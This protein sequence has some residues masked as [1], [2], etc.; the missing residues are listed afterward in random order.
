MD[1]AFAEYLDTYGLTLDHAQQFLIHFGE[2]PGDIP[3]FFT[4]MG[5]APDTLQRWIAH[6]NEYTSRVDAQ[7]AR[8]VADPMNAAFGGTFV[9]RVGL[10]TPPGLTLPVPYG[11]LTEPGGIFQGKAC[12]RSHNSWAKTCT[13]WKCN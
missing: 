7:Y 10:P 4:R 1:A 6:K 9:P 11:P 8:W 12:R 13:E 2:D 5:L 3:A